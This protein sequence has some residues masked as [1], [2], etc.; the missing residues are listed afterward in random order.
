MQKFKIIIPERMTGERIDIAIAQMLPD[1][2]RSKISAY[3]KSAK[4]LINDNTFM[5]KDIVRGDEI[6]S[7]SYSDNKTT[8]W[9]ATEMP[10]KIVFEDDD[11]MLID[12]PVGVVTHPGAGNLHNTLANGL[13][14]YKAD[15]SKLDRAG[16]VHRLDK[17]TSGLMVVAKT[18][19]AQKY[20]TQQL[21][22]H[23]VLRE[24]KAIVYGNIISGG[25]I[26]K[27][28]ARDSRDRK[29]QSINNNGKQAKTHYRI[30]ER[31]ANHTYI[32][33]ILETGRTHQIRVH[34]AHIGYP[35]VGDF[36]Y[37]GKLK[38]PKKA[39]YE[40]KQGLKNFNRQALHSAKLEL[41]H[42]INNTNIHFE[43]ALP[44]DMA[45][46]LDV[47]RLYDSV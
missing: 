45:Q 15:L 30:I 9:L 34:M 6:I 25:T 28:I 17:N 38:F 36:I 11:I 1:Y 32:K 3:I 39:D 41:N 20:L 27:A 23:R 8:K 24:Y 33:V 21:Q 10:L 46:L 43:S 18:A 44:N 5:P 19:K 4:M 14:F 42:P 7:F 29:K 12:K 22:N 37:G 31:F 26:D 2:S 35:L 40:L 47:L 16:I 13:L